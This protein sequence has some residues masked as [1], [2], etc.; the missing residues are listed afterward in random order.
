MSIFNS[1][2]TRVSTGFRVYGQKITCTGLCQVEPKIYVLNIFLVYFSMEQFIESL[3]A[4]GLDSDKIARARKRGIAYQCLVCERVGARTVN[5][6]CRL[7]DH[8]MRR[9]M[10]EEEI[11]FRCRLCGFMCLRRDQML[12]HTTVY[13]RHI[14]A[15]T[16]QKIADVTPY[17]VESQRPHVF[18]PG[19]YK[20]LTQMESLVHF[21]GVVDDSQQQTITS[22][23]LLN[24]AST[25]SAFRPIPASTAV[26]TVVPSLVPVGGIGSTLLPGQVPINLPSAST[27]KAQ[28][29]LPGDTPLTAGQ[30]DLTNQLTAVL[31]AIAKLVPDSQG[32]QPLDLCMKAPELIAV[33]PGDIGITVY[34]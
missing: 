14:L 15:V 7:E 10:L 16:K 25:V 6:K 31:E 13:S 19:D 3:V 30:P 21:L 34:N 28:M 20:A 24:S 26:A 1:M 33:G 22:P 29:L 4:A 17:L 12:N 8:F 32:E 11:P 27:T 18:G 5:I 9:H 23:V 2:V